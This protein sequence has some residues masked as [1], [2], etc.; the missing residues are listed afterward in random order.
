MLHTLPIPQREGERVFLKF[1]RSNEKCSTGISA[2]KKQLLRFY[3][4]YVP[5][6]PAVCVLR[7]IRGSDRDERIKRGSDKRIVDHIDKNALCIILY[8]VH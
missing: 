6:V 7:E 4:G 8:I 3:S 5:K 2:S 1:D